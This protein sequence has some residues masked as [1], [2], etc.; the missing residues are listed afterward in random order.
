[1]TRKVT[2]KTAKT[3][4]AA[5]PKPAKKS[6]KPKE[7]VAFVVVREIPAE[8]PTFTEPERVFAAKSAARKFADERNGDLRRLV[9]PFDDHGP[10]FLVRGG[11]KALSAFLKKL[12]LPAPKK[13]KSFGYSYT[14]WAAWWDTHYFD[15]T[16]EERNA[17]WDA[18]DK[19]HWYKVK[20][21]KVE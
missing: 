6:A 10:D 11:E 20:A 1:M 12:R 4:R 17:I 7:V 14:D 8:V 18:L 19:Y 15:M 9:N 21:T 16:D 5:G 3:G 2:K 13:S